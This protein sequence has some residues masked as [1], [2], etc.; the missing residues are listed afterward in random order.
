MPLRCRGTFLEVVDS[1]SE[2]SMVHSRSLPLGDKTHELEKED[3][4]DELLRNVTDAFSWTFD[5]SRSDL[6]RGSFG[7]PWLCKSPCIRAF[8]GKCFKGVQCDF[9][10]VKHEM[11]KHKIFKSERRYL[12]S[13]DEGV[14]LAVFQVL[15]RRQAARYQLTENLRLVLLVLDRRVRLLKAPLLSKGV[16]AILTSMKRLSL[17]RLFETFEHCHQ[18]EAEFRSEIKCLVD[19]ARALLPPD[20]A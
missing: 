1:D 8:Y 18:I 16:W 11:N 10:H 5:S 2:D 19:G 17:G 14:A 15:I 9:C 12:M 7:H 3:R 6:S 13:L 20:I 4:I